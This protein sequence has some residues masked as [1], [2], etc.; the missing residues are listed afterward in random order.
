MFYDRKAL[1]IYKLSQSF[2]VNILRCHWLWWSPQKEG[3]GDKVG[4][5]DIATPAGV[6]RTGSILR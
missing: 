5:K 3:V 6:G 1:E 4:D 2:V